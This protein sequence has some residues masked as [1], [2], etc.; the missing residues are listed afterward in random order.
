MTAVSTATRHHKPANPLTQA[1]YRHGQSN[2]TQAHSGP[3]CRLKQLTCAFV[4]VC[5]FLSSQQ[6]QADST[7]AGDPDTALT[8][9]DSSHIQAQ[10]KALHWHSDQLAKMHQAIEDEEFK[11]ISSVLI[12]HQGQ[13][14]FEGYYNGSRIDTL[15]DTRSAAKSLTSLLLGAAI[16]SGKIANVAA[17]VYPFFPDKQ[18]VAHPDPRKAE[19]QI[20]D[21]LS[22][23]SLWECNDDNN[24]SRGNEERMYI[25]EDWEQFALDLP[26][27]GFAPWET[28]PADAPYGRS[29][30]YCTAGSFIVGAI[31]QRAVG[32]KLDTYAKQVFEQPLGILQSEWNESPLGVTM[33]GGGARY[34]SRDWIKIGE[35]VRS[36][37]R[38]QG[39][40]I[41]PASWI[42][43]M[44]EPR[45]QVRENVEYG[46]LWWRMR[47]PQEAVAESPWFWVAAGNGGNYLLVQPELELVILIT[48]Q[49]YNT[50]HG[51]PQSQ[52]LVREF[53]LP[54][55]P[56]R[57]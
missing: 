31:I 27:K 54:A 38:W 26:I 44:T 47:F 41:L 46:Y 20:E 3:A 48:S 30:S 14:V 33:G 57:G 18:P 7:Q 42:K 34:R 22:M 49:A 53:I 29:F 28:R 9:A 24:F 37:G 56:G 17:P 12:A 35:L 40:Q 21:L 11:Q 4:L 16:N 2:R 32:M 51:H 23:S 50:P 1:A 52:R 13:L 55:M 5:S 43:A 15:H 39:Q 25:I 19:I 45:A 10:A 8:P 6:S 36:S